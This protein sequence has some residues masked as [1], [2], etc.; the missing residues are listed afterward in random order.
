[1]GR[2]GPIARAVGRGWSSRRAVGHSGRRG[3]FGGHERGGRVR[4]GCGD[5]VGLDARGNR[6]LDLGRAGRRRQLGLRH[7]RR[8]A[9]GSS[10]A[11][12]GW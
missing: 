7:L 2:R 3:A 4:R 12:C 9:D 6:P 10:G 5:A 8:R 11:H 1:M